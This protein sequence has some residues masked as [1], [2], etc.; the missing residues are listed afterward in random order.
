MLSSTKKYSGKDA[1]AGVGAKAKKVSVQEVGLKEEEED[2]GRKWS[3]EGE[4]SWLEENNKW[5]SSKKSKSSLCSLLLCFTVFASD[6]VNNRIDDVKRLV[7]KI[8]SRYW[9]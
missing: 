1:R 6:C 7:S 8:Q 4:N 5:Q 3:I 2:M 9:I